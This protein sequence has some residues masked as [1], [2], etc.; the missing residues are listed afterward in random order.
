MREPMNLNFILKNP[1]FLMMGFTMLMVMVLP[2]MMGT[3]CYRCRVLRFL[4]MISD[5]EAMKEMQNDETMKSMFGGGGDADKSGQ[6]D[7]IITC[8]TYLLLL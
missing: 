8:N 6:T 1:M 2:K 5:P 4:C 3:Y 7:D